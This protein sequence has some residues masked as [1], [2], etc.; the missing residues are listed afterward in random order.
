MPPAWEQYIRA[1][2]RLRQETRRDVNFLL[3]GDFLLAG[4]GLSRGV[5][6]RSGRSSG[7]SDA[8][9]RNGLSAQ[10]VLLGGVDQSGQT[11]QELLLQ[12]SGEEA[13]LLWAEE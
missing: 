1:Q 9:P 5:L 4:T 11:A 13:T 8:G 2:V 7:R 6:H 12:S 3:A 10:Q